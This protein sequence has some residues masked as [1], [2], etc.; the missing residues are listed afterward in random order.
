MRFTPNH[1]RV[2][3]R[4]AGACRTLEAT[5]FALENV[6]R[7]VDDVGQEREE[8]RRAFEFLATVSQELR[9]PLSSILA[10][11][12]VLRI[13]DLDADDRARAAEEILRN[14]RAQSRLFDEL[15]RMFRESTA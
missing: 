12:E 8:L 2:T 11:G 6:V 14:A 3:N 1:P 7:P 4:D 10:W 5:S 15:Q 13:T 9:A